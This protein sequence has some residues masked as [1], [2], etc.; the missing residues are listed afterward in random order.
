MQRETLKWL[1]ATD[2]IVP[3]AQDQ[4]FTPEML[5]AR[6]RG[7][8]PPDKEE[9]VRGMIAAGTPFPV[10]MNFCHSLAEGGTKKE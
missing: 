2:D 4:R 9:Q 10:L 5:W 8:V 3:F 6:V 7:L 1:Q